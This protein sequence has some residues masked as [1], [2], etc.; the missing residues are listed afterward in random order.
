[1]GGIK[2]ERKN[3][4]FSWTSVHFSD[5]YSDLMLLN[6]ISIGLIESFGSFYVTIGIRWVWIAARVQGY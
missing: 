5:D 3:S 6:L 4:T 2:K 1:M